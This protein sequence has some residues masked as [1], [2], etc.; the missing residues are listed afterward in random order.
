M[1]DDTGEG[2][3]ENPGIEELGCVTG[4]SF[5]ESL[6]KMIYKKCEGL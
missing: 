1:G 5:C 4:I 2:V 6:L 3:I